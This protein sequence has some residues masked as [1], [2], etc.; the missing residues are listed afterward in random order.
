MM[1]LRA[2][3][4]VAAC[5][6]GSFTNAHAV[7]ALRLEQ[8]FQRAIAGHPELL[9][10]D[11]TQAGWIAD[12]EQAAL[13]PARSLDATV[14]N[15]FGSG[16]ASGLSA[17]EI[18]LSL[19]S[20]I[21]RGDKRD[22]RMAVAAQ[23]LDGVELLREAKR[24]D[25]LAEVARRFLDAS[26]A[27]LAMSL[28]ADEI[29]VR[30]RMLDAASRRVAAGGA[31]ESVRLT[32]DV[33]VVRAQ[34]DLLRAQRS[35]ALANRRL[36][37]MWGQTSAVF[38]VA[39]AGFA[40][41]PSVGD[42]EGLLRR[43]TQSPQ[44]RRFAHEARLR[45]ARVQLARSASVTD[46]QWHVGARR[47]QSGNDWALVGGVSIPLGGAGRA[48]PGIR[49]AESELAA[50]AF[51]RDGATRTLEATLAEIWGALDQAVADAIQIDTQLLPRLELAAQ[52][53]ERAYRNGALGF[54]EW[55][56][57]GTEISSA[58]RQRVELGLAAHRALI[59]LQRLTGEAH[60]TPA[61]AQESRP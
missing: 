22:A 23:R 4:L 3:L 15:A 30:Q 49:S 26:A 40:N 1:I 29:K 45:E 21:E 48:E 25:I 47:L 55:A 58:R 28:V 17:A 43:V 27:Q 8:A 10:L 7:E 46:I 56:Q 59:E 18:T 39:T 6:F 41:L 51:E 54:L 2:T 57:L 44:L 42:L 9:A 60:T 35:V 52:A 5:L 61:P 13:Q 53:A 12:A 50:L 31:P 38:T 32:A 36:A 11:Q 14:E 34:G 37:M 19:Q 33:A 16:E 24:L 20:V